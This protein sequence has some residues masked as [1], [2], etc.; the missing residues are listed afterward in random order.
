MRKMDEFDSMVSA[1]NYLN[2]LGYKE[3]FRADE[4]F[5][6]GLYGKGEFQPNQLT[7]VDYVRFD[8]MTDPEDESELFVLTADDGT[9]GTLVMSYS[10]EHSQNVELI[11]QIKFQ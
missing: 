11:K 10:A 5:I 6:L 3:D 8:G 2:K 9:Q 1:I 7:I 4:H